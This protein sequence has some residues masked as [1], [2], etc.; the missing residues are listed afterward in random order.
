MTCTS[1][2][3]EENKRCTCSSILLLL[4]GALPPPSVIYQFYY[5]AQLGRDNWWPTTSLLSLL[6]YKSNTHTHT[7]FFY[8][9]SAAAYQLFGSILITFQNAIMSQFREAYGPLHHARNVL[10]SLWQ[11]HTRTVTSGPLMSTRALSLP[12]VMTTGRLSFHKVSPVASIQLQGQ[13]RTD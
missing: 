10:S 13:Y 8:A 6:N 4:R 2:N 3:H 5:D 12:T 9:F 7:M 11:C 1:R